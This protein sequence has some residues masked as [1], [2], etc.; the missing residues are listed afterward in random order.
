M[1]SFLLYGS[2]GY[3]GSLIARLAVQR[4]LRPTLAGRDEEKLRLQ[5]LDLGLDHRPFPLEDSDQVTDILC[6]S[7]LV[8]HCAGPFSQTSQPMAQACLR[9]GAHYLDITGEITVFE[10]LAGLD[11]LAKQAGVMLLPGVGFDVVPT[12]CL[13]LHLKNRLPSAT[14]LALGL[15]SVGGAV[16]R[17]TALT[18]LERLNGWGAVRH[19]GK[20]TPVPLGH[21]IRTFDFGSGR[22][23]G[24][25][26]A[27][28]IPWGDVSTAWYSTGIPNIG[29]YN[30]N[31]G[32]WGLLMR[33]AWIIGPILQSKL[34][35]NALKGYVRTRFKGPTPEQNEKGKM[36]VSG[37][38]KDEKGNSARARLETPEAYWTTALTAL[39][40][41]EKVLAGQAQPGFQ[42]PAKAFG[43]DLILEM[44]GV[45][46][47]ALS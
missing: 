15:L 38:V 33:L 28:A 42:T 1:S 5:A 24:Y 29:V 43:A 44:E 18:G 16:S 45:K 7:P 20:I 35:S 14:H 17:G 3:T 46:R 2:Y 36:I 31:G 13:A 22:P 40:V 9:T 10:T 11:A 25:R 8:L 32:R 23:G 6:A 12:D 41:V 4:G 47:E 39:A 37:E 27:S 21:K 34:V 26:P 19:Q 30:A